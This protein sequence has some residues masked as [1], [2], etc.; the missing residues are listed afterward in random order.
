MPAHSVLPFVPAGAQI[1]KDM[2]LSATP[3]AWDGVLMFIA[4]YT[5][6]ENG[7]SPVNALLIGGVVHWVAHDII[8]ERILMDPAPNANRL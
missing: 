7:V 5:A 1:A 2:G 8:I 3:M 4:A 6:L